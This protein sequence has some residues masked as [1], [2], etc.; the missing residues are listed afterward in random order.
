[1]PLENLSSMKSVSLPSVSLPWAL[2][3]CSVWSSSQNYDIALIMNI[4]MPC[5]HVILFACC[6]NAIILSFGARAF[7]FWNKLIH[8]ISIVQFYFL[9]FAVQ[10]SPERKCA[11]KSTDTASHE[12]F[13]W[14]FETGVFH[15]S[16]KIN[17]LFNDYPVVF[18]LY[19]RMVQ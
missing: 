19:S 8:Y 3:D 10:H 11:N 2:H 14:L 9:S 17:V 4:F 16:C 18:K 6:Q 12:R 5:F 15:F 7:F 13:Q 1:M